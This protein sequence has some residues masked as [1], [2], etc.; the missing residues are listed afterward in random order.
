MQLPEPEYNNLWLQDLQMIAQRYGWNPKSL[1]KQQ[2]SCNMHAPTQHLLPSNTS[3]Q[4]LKHLL[5]MVLFSD[6]L[7]E[8]NAYNTCVSISNRVW[9]QHCFKSHLWK[10]DFVQAHKV[11]MEFSGLEWTGRNMG[12]T[13]CRFST[14]IV[15]FEW[16]A[17]KLSITSR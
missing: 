15:S 3:L 2:V 10:R 6:L 17:E 11:S 13:P 12:V 9:S 4:T 5:A 1:Q 16:W 7:K 8:P 14:S